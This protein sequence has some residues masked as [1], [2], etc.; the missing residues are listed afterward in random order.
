ME[1][2][3]SAKNLAAI[4]SFIE[5]SRAQ[6]SADDIRSGKAHYENRKAYRQIYGSGTR[7]VMALIRK[8]KAL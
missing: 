4:K 5:V 7:E 2:T 1:T 6:Y 8:E 3:N